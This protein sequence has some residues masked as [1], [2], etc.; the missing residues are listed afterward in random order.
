M[1]N[2]GSTT[3]SR[4]SHG[5]QLFR[6]PDG[7]RVCRGTPSGTGSALGCGHACPGAWFFAGPGQLRNECSS[8]ILASVQHRA[9][10]DLLSSP[11]TFA[12]S[13]LGSGPWR[14]PGRSRERWRGTKAVNGRLNIIRNP[15]AS[16]NQSWNGKAS[17]HARSAAA[18]GL[19][20]SF[21]PSASTS[22]RHQ[23]LVVL[24]HQR[25]LAPVVARFSRR[26]RPAALDELDPSMEDILNMQ[27]SPGF[28]LWLYGEI[29]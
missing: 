1:H 17:E 8:K 9:S 21:A 14:V 7:K 4:R 16:H 18:S 2:Q 28:Q 3:P 5:L 6:Q 15:I 13:H 25:T 10:I 22:A 23:Q 24:F 12:A 29:S 20:R 26:T 19:L 11:F 27:H